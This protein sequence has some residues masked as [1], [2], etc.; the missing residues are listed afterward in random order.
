MINKSFTLVEVLIA[1]FLLTVGTVGAIHAIVRVIEATEVSSS[2]L[3]ASYLAQE[4]IEIVRNI[5]DTN[6]LEARTASN[7]WDEGLTNCSGGCIA[8]YKHSYGPN[9][10][11]PTLPAYNN[12]FLNID[13]DG[14]YSYSTGPP[15]IF[16]RKIT[17]TP[18]GSDI[19]KVSVTVYWTERGKS[20][21]V[22]AQ[23]DLYYWLKR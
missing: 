14:F 6:W 15:T 1:M 8:D 16:Q 7:P 13:T 17:I 23:E 5:R 19:L 22:T 9:Q 2:Q 10:L 4:G 11:D 21:S 20:Y 3:I 12:Q 18:D